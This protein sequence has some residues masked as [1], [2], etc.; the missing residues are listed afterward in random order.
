MMHQHI[1]TADDP[2]AQSL[3]VRTGPP[4]GWPATSSGNDCVYSQG[5]LLDE[6]VVAQRVELSE[7]VQQIG[8]I[9]KPGQAFGF[10]TFHADQLDSDN[11]VKGGTTNGA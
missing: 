9:E 10:F 1:L 8:K 4:A 6:E 7:L 3:L 2:L 5:T 11:R